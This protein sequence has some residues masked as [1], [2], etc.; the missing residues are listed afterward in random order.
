MALA[1]RELT[2]AQGLDPRD[3]TLV[4][5]GGAGPMHAAEIALEAGISQVI[6]PPVPGMFSAWGMLAADIRHDLVTTAVAK[7]DDLTAEQIESTFAA[8]EAEG[9]E[10][11][12]SQNVADDA[13]RFIRSLDLRYFGQEHTLEV[14]V[15]TG[16]DPAALK[17]LF[18]RA[19]W[20]KYGHSSD[21]DPVELVNFR[22][23][24]IGHVPKPDLKAATGAG[25]ADATATGV[26]EV[27]FDG[28]FV[29]AAVYSRSNIPP[30]SSLRGPAVIDEE[31]ATLVVPP[32]FDVL[33]DPYGNLV[34]SG[35][36][37]LETAKEERNGVHA[38]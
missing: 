31:G 10:V 6:F 35:A 12:A 13:G 3:F 17:D 38:G 30:R 7:A 14:E 32:G 34:L 15:P 20:R 1:I 37:R 23:A 33:C 22:V 21:I 2:V 26:R 29:T 16:L 8:L 9:R 4:A 27:Y 18:D 19:H 24:A 25:T 11:L 28:R 5:F 36:A